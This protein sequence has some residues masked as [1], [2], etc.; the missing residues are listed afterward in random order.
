MDFLWQQKMSI[1][2]HVGP[3]CLQAHNTTIPI[4]ITAPS[5]TI[6]LPPRPTRLPPQTPKHSYMPNILPPPKKTPN[7]NQLVNVYV[8]Q[9]W[10]KKVKDNV[11]KFLG[12]YHLYQ[13]KGCPSPFD[14]DYKVRIGS[15]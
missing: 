7:S 14:D 10:L 13:Q 4:A 6:P 12:K 2:T 9:L 5:Y 11:S 3:S 8:Y 1:A 15:P